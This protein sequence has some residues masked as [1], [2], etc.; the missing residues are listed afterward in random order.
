MSGTPVCEME[1]WREQVFEAG[2]FA[3][4]TKQPFDPNAMDEWIGGYRLYLASHGLT[5]MISSAAFSSARNAAAPR[6]NT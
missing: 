6:L 2:Y 4:M 3:A 5:P 1:T